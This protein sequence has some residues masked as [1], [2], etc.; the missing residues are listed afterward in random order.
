MVL[1]EW[2]V[3][4]VIWAMFWF[5]VFFLWIWLVIAVF[6]DLIGSDDLGG[7]A[8]ALWCLFVI[9]TPYLGVFVYLIAR[10]GTMRE[11]AEADARERE[12]E[13]RE[14]IQE[15]AGTAASPGAEVERLANLRAQ[16]VIDE[17]EFQALKAKALA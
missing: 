5:T 2:Q 3:G 14:Y 1:A 8:K 15:A 7:W 13:Q 10:D 17:A 12:V 6:V 11:R 16:G 4:E 9:V